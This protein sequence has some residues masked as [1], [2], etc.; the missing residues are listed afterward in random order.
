MWLRMASITMADAPAT[1]AWFARSLSVWAGVAGVALVAA[2]A[3]RLAGARAAL[4][5]TLAA[6]FSPFWL[7]ESQETRMYTLAIALLSVAAYALLVA[8]NEARPAPAPAAA[9]DLC[10]RFGGGAAN[11]L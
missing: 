9:G 11:A 6:A 7:A 8:Q 10:R 2:L 1:I 3:Q 5:A 4:F